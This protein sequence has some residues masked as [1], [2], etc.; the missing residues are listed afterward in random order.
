M[1]SVLFLF[2]C[3]SIQFCLSS[4]DLLKIISLD[5]HCEKKQCAILVCKL[6]VISNSY[7]YTYVHRDCVFYFL[8]IYI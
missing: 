3:F 7:M 6:T 8:Y 1:F 2:L 5:L 4:D